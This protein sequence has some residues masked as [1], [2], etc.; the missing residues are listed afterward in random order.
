MGTGG[1]VLKT[2]RP[3]SGFDSI[4]AGGDIYAG[5]G[6]FKGAPDIF[7]V[8][9]NPAGHGSSMYS[10][11]QSEQTMPGSGGFR[12]DWVGRNHGTG[13]WKSKKTN[14]G[15]VDGH[16]EIKSVLDT[17]APNFE[18]GDKVFSLNADAAN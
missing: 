12:L 11:L 13:A 1:S 10:Q 6:G 3:V 18:W 17:L 7:K 8:K 16:V 5:G 2:H 4:S 15:Y 9:P 14:F